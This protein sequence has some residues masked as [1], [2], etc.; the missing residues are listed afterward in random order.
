MSPLLRNILFIIAVTPSIAVGQPEFPFQPK[1]TV[2]YEVV[3]NVGFLWLNAA[4]V[5]F[6][7]SEKIYQDKPVF[8]FVSIG[9]TNPNYDWFFTVRDT[10]ISY[11]DRNDLRSYFAS[12]NTLEG[13]YRVNDLL[14]FDT[15]SGIITANLYNNRQ[16]K[17]QK[18]LKPKNPAM[19]VLTAVYFC[20]TLDYSYLNLDQIVPIHTIIDD[21]VYSLYIRYKGREELQMPDGKKYKT[22]KISVKLVEGTIFR[23]GEDMHVWFTDDLVKIPLLVDAKI[24]IGSVKAYLLSTEHLKFPIEAGPY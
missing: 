24:L 23:S 8:R 15:K 19:D 21:S 2:R 18:H 10:F 20:R 13:S 4:K 12:R 5:T 6:E 17:R 11:A 1:E 3:Y 7:V 9:T 16:G 22:H 14:F